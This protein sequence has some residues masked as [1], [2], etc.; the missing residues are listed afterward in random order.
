MRS[1]LILIILAII[2]GQN[3]NEQVAQPMVGGVA[4]GMN[5][6]LNTHSVLP[7]LPIQRAQMR[8]P[9]GI[10]DRSDDHDNNDLAMNLPADMETPL[11]SVID[12]HRAPSVPHGHTLVNQAGEP[13]FSTVFGLLSLNE[14]KEVGLLD[15][16]VGDNLAA[17]SA[18]GGL[19][20][21]MAMHD[22][23]SQ[24]PFVVTGGQPLPEMDV[25]HQQ[26]RSRQHSMSGSFL[27]ALEM[28]FQDSTNAM[29]AATTAAIQALQGQEQL[30]QSVPTLQPHQPNMQLH[31]PSARH[32]KTIATSNPSATMTA[33]GN[34]HSIN[35]SSASTAAVSNSSIPAPLRISQS[36]PAPTSTILSHAAPV[37]VSTST[38]PGAAPPVPGPAPSLSYPTAQSLIEARRLNDIWR[39]YV[40]SSPPA[41]SSIS[42]SPSSTS[43]SLSAT[44]TTSS[45]NVDVASLAPTITPTSRPSTAT[46][47][48]GSQTT[49]PIREIRPLPAQYIATGLPTAA[50]PPVINGS[51]PSSSSS[52][53]VDVMAHGGT[54]PRGGSL[55]TPTNTRLQ[56]PV[57]SVSRVRAHTGP[58]YQLDAA[59]AQAQAQAQIESSYAS[60]P[61]SQQQSRVQFPAVT[62][63]I[64]SQSIQILDH[65]ISFDDFVSLDDGEGQKPA[66]KEEE[67]ENLQSYEQAV[68]ARNA[69]R[70]MKLSLGRK[71]LERVRTASANG[72][73]GLAANSASSLSSPVTSGSSNSSNSPNP[74]LHSQSQSQ[75]QFSNAMDCVNS[76]SPFNFEGM[77]NLG[78]MEFDFE[79]GTADDSSGT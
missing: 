4:V 56:A 48:L 24:S 73:V 2:I 57:Q 62:T 45:Q 68:M 7:L 5:A 49:Y 35:T 66:K 17:A 44:G 16:K 67:E 72:A 14:A 27:H 38:T 12:Y 75:D 43:A 29:T 32:R 37:N 63:H 54:R 60:F 28:P 59:Q 74:Q 36:I 58:G 42:S 65:Q 76:S 46:S 61:G 11:S 15:G 33:A 9:S 51:Q 53:V 64:S 3:M 13:L 34:V 26:A 69:M 8:V 40:T 1:D 19:S 18:A 55:P 6:S 30:S 71:A 70:P 22:S 10:D 77:D 20:L 41:I 47:L 50:H 25:Q 21:P 79:L 78:R 31:L 39:E 52:L 23:I